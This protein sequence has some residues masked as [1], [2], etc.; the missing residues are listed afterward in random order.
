MK[1]YCTRPRQQHEAPHL[2]EIPDQNLSGSHSCQICG[3]PLILQDR[4][5]PIDELG[6]GGFGHTFLALDLKFGLESRRA[7]KQFRADL[8]LLPSAIAQAK[9]A[10]KREYETLDRLKHQQI[11]RIYEPFEIQAL[12]DV[13]VGVVENQQAPDYY[14]F[15]QEYIQGADLARCLKTDRV[16]TEVEV[17][18]ILHQMLQVLQYIHSQSPPI[19]HRDIKPSNIIRADD[20][21]FYL[22]DF[23][24]IKQTLAEVTM[25][26]T[27]AE[28]NFVTRGF[29]P[30][31]QYHGFVDF[32]SDLYA[33]G[34]TCI[35]LLEG[36]MLPPN[37]WKPTATVSDTLV[38][39]LNQMT[40]E[41]PDHRYTST[42]A[43][44]SDLTPETFSDDRQLLGYHGWFKKMAIGAGIMI[45]L[46]G[47]SQVKDIFFPQLA[48][49]SIEFKPPQYRNITNVQALPSGEFKSCCSK[50]WI[51]LAKVVNPIIQQSSQTF[52]LESVSPQSGLRNSEAG[53][54]MLIDG[55]IDI[56]L[57]SKQITPELLQQA[58]NKNVRLMET[59]IARGSTAVVVHPS[60][61]IQGITIDQFEQ[62][63]N[64]K[65]TNWKEVG[66]TD[67]PIAIYMTDGSYLGKNIQF[68]QLSDT[69]T[70]FERVAKDRGGFTV[71]PS[72][73]AA[74]HCQVRTLSIG[75]SSN[76]LVSPYRDQKVSAT[77]VCNQDRVNID[78]IKNGKYPI[79]S[80]LK[81]FFRA[82]D[83]IRKQL[84]QVYATMLMT[85][86]LQQRIEEAGYLPITKIK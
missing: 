55:K 35:C 38:K 72:N 85:T 44:M 19:I 23:G 24:A 15:V 37:S 18:N 68:T 75:I 25:G 33:L 26:S 43:V 84:G 1:V 21:S 54:E 47:L 28:T 83:P 42:T 74:T 71:V 10:F 78:V 70:I 46:L 7:I 86:E 27:Q 56:A 66:G 69:M 13:R 39:I 59:T 48:I 12:P 9:R 58:A 3:M 45:S 76:K 82:D 40:A 29:S 41:E 60:L 20:E 64:G 8:L 17:R 57:S 30:P 65:I 31:E 16:F 50:T 14:Y 36:T 5:V 53:I 4:Y 51:P 22:I 80:D 63:K 6:Q 62:I 79:T 11:P 77:S 73:L 67:L 49:Q 52:R 81:V 32:S 34:K 61:P 2:T